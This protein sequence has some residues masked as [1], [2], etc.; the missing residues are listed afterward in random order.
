MFSKN[1]QSLLIINLIRYNSTFS[2]KSLPKE[3]QKA[4]DRI[5]RVDHAGIHLYF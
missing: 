5:I 4:L 3:S 2:Y 1:K